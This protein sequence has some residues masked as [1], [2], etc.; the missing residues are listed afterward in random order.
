M[1]NKL[2]NNGF[3]LVE[4]LMALVIASI[5]LAAVST[6]AGAVTA[7]DQITDQMGR[8]QSQLRQVSMRLTDLIRCSN[9]ITTGS[10]D[11]FQLWHDN[12]HDGLMTANELTQV[13]RGLDKNTLTIGSQEVYRNCNNISFG[14]DDLDNPRFVTVS[15][16]MTEDGQTQHY[17]INA[18]L[19]VSDEHRQF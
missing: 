15:F 7:A 8:Q 14:Y 11:G 4:L 5:V 3:T 10:A 6:L 18:H 2:R 13:I 16:D 12:N 1:K 9:A 19:R 17:S